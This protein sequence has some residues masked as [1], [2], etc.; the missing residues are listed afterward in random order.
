MNK[1]LTMAIKETK[2][3]L[4]SVCNESGLPPIILDLIMQGI[5]SEIHSLAQRQTSEDEAAY[6]KMMEESENCCGDCQ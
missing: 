2:L 3:K 1:P 4:A 5:Y 6:A